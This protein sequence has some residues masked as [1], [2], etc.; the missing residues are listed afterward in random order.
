MDYMQITP[1]RQNTVIIGR[2]ISKSKEK[3]ATSRVKA[4]QEERGA[5]RGEKRGGE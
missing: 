2:L 4:S 1:G 3:M 5:E